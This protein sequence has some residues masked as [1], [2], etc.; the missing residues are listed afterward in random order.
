[1]LKET[2]QETNDRIDQVMLNR[3]V[4]L[5]AH[6]IGRLRSMES[7]IAHITGLSGVKAMELLRFDNGSLGIAFNLD[8]DEIGAVLLGSGFN[9]KAGSEVR[10]TGRVIDVPVGLE[11]LGR[12]VDGLGHPL[13]D[14]G[15]IIAE[16]RWAIEREAPAIMDRDP[17]I[18]PLQTGIKV[19][20][21]LIPI[22]RGQR[23]LV[24][25]D[26]QTGKTAIV[27]D[28]I[29]HQRDK[30]VICVYCS[31]GQRGSAVAKVIETLRA[32]KAME[33]SLDP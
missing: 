2:L 19:I 6:E 27:L 16:N 4:R 24:L 9:L 32:N 7:G 20:D 25:G 3:R 8:Q 1:M 26:R 14:S 23:Q 31:I 12:V 30:N 13:D 21:A 22:G 29:I 17:V 28:T 5:S 15:P 11:L 33:H 10:R 18:T